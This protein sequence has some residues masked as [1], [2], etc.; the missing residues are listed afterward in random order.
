MT[1][2]RKAGFLE[3]QSSSDMYFDLFRRLQAERIIPAFA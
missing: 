3:Y 2:C 1:R